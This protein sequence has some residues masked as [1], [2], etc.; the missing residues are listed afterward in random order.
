MSR[1]LPARRALPAAAVDLP[2]V[3]GE[4]VAALPARPEDVLAALDDPE[5]V[6]AV[7]AVAWALARCRRGSSAAFL[8]YHRR[9]VAA[10]LE[11][12]VPGLPW[13]VRAGLA[14][15]DGPGAS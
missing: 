13:R 9:Q 1:W 7:A 11:P 15:A 3:I 10:G 12:R 8:E 6:A 4:V 2:P 14:A 5:V